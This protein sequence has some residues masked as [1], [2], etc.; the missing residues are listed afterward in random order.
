MA[1]SHAA[2]FASE[3]TCANDPALV[4]LAAP[5]TS[6]IQFD[7]NAVAEGSRCDSPRPSRHSHGSIQ[8]SLIVREVP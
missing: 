1:V 4:A 7:R 8:A 5:P 6:V 3:G 2:T